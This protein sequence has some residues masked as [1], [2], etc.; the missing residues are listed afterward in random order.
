MGGRFAVKQKWV[1]KSA[2][3]PETIQVW[4][5]PCRLLMLLNLAQKKHHNRFNNEHPGHP[6]KKRRK[7]L[8]QAATERYGCAWNVL[9]LLIALFHFFEVSSSGGRW[10]KFFFM[11]SKMGP[12]MGEVLASTLKEY[13]STSCDISL[14]Y[15][16]SLRFIFTPRKIGEDDKMDPNLNLHIFVKLGNLVYSAPWDDFFHMDRH[17]PSIV[18]LIGWC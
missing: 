16:F 2:T 18:R 4:K 10:W 5:F 8:P 7:Q 3:I 1:R 9:D 15:M 13:L 6:L 14:L 12:R 17:P 11:V